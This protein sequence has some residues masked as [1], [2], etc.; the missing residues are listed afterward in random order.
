MRV[1][2]CSMLVAATPGSGA[3]GMCV[4]VR[5]RNAR[6]KTG[7]FTIARIRQI[8][9]L[10]LHF[11]RKKTGGKLDFAPMRGYNN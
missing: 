2:S 5:G 7:L 1:V 11:F 4:S 9:Q 10:R 6:A 8:F 3:H